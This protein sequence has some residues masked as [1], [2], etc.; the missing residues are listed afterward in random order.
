MS[1]ITVTK[2]GGSNGEVPYSIETKDLEHIMEDRYAGCW[3]YTLKSTWAKYEGGMGRH[4]KEEIEE[5]KRL[6]GSDWTYLERIVERT[7]INKEV[8]FDDY[9]EYAEEEE[10]TDEELWNRSW[11]EGNTEGG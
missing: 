5:L 6:I 10:V 4:I 7:R 1:I 2:I 8:V 11:D 3:L 9:N